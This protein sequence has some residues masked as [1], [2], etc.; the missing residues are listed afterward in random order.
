MPIE[1]TKTA[2]EKIRE[3][4]DQRKK[5]L[6]IKI[7]IKKTG[8]SGYAYAIEFVDQ[9]LSTN[10]AVEKTYES[11]SV[12][13]DHRAIPYLEGSTIDWVVKGLNQGFEFVNPKEKDRCGCGE[14][15]RV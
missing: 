12:W 7:T 1:L 15:F 10:E 5:G 4:L 14:S 8:C 6:G 3:K 13:V 2:I 9:S 11:F